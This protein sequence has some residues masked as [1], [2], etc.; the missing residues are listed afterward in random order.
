MEVNRSA[1]VHLIDSGDTDPNRVIHQQRVHSRGNNVA[2]HVV[3]DPGTMRMPGL[4]AFLPGDCYSMCRGGIDFVMRDDA[5]IGAY[6]SD[7]ARARSN[8]GVVV[9]GD[10]S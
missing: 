5:V 8:A 9:K 10:V 2:N 3:L 4:I 6:A 7:T 1:V